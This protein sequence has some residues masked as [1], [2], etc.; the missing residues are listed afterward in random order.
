MKKI[1]IIGSIILVV[2]IFFI[3][4]S[5]RSKVEFT[6]EYVYFA[7]WKNDPESIYCFN[8][9]KLIISDELKNKDFD[10]LD[11]DAPYFTKNFTN[12]SSVWYFTSTFG[13]L[14]DGKIYF[15]QKNKAIKWGRPYFVESYVKR[16]ELDWA[17][18]EVLGV[19]ELNA[20]YQFNGIRNDYA[21]FLYIDKEGNTHTFERGY[22]KGPW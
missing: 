12:D 19:L 21:I 22:Y 9:E 8:I 15:N 7:G 11:I 13:K 3:A 2:V 16:N 20:W 6:T 10:E 18:K 14:E 1:S 4:R 5:C 17:D